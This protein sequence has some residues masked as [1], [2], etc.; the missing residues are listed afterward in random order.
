MDDLTVTSRDDTTHGHERLATVHL[1]FRVPEAAADRWRKM[2]RAAGVSFSDFIRGAVR[3][4]EMTWASPGSRKKLPGRDYKMTDPA[5][6]RQIILIGNNLNQIA[7]AL[8]SNKSNYI[9]QEKLFNAIETIS[10]ELKRITIESK[11]ED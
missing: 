8:N 1:G 4:S 9:N 6:L 10:S 3:D 11:R 2:A 7:R 5:L